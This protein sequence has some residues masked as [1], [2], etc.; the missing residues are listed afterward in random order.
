MG[1]RDALRYQL[2]AATGD[3]NALGRRRCDEVS[4]RIGNR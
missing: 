1:H 3:G 2:I 4:T